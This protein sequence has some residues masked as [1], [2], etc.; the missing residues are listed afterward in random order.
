MD[1]PSQ[2]PQHIIHTSESLT[3][4][5]VLGILGAD[6]TSGLVH[7]TLDSWGSIDMPL[8]G[9]VQYYVC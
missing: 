2:P 8:I 1:D 6:F 7:W 4:I 9:K 5:I 3:G